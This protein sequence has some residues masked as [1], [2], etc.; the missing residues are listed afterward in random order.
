MLV[1][2]GSRRKSKKRAWTAMEANKVP[3]TGES[4]CREASRGRR[5]G[6]HEIQGWQG[7]AGSRQAGRKTAASASALGV[8]VDVDGSWASRGPNLSA[9]WRRGSQ[10]AVL[11][12]WLYCEGACGARCEVRRESFA[13]LLPCCPRGLCATKVC[14]CGGRM[15]GRSER[16]EP[17]PT[18]RRWEALGAGGDVWVGAGAGAAKRFD[19]DG[20]GSGG[21]LPA[22]GC[23]ERAL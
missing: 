6:V 23:C 16:S 5:R 19:G 13:V 14:V 11:R 20:G 17:L 7:R 9:Q 21:R 3:V 8:G 4:R 10:S 12:D 2:L 15:S 18:T 1:M 22:E